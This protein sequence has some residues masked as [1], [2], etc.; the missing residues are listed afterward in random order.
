MSR[1]FTKQITEADLFRPIVSDA[2]LKSYA[3]TPLHQHVQH[4][5][6]YSNN[7]FNLGKGRLV[8]DV[9]F[10]RSV[11]R[12]FSHPELSDIPGL[13]L[14]LNSYMYD[15]KYY[16]PEWSGWQL[17]T[18]VNGMFQQNRVTSG[19]EF[20]IPSYRQFDLGPFAM[21]KKNFDKLDFSAGIR[22]D[23]RSFNNDALYTGT[24]PVTGF[25]Q[26]VTGA[27]TAGAA[28]PFSKYHHVF[29]GVSGSL[30]LTYAFSPEW[31]AKA[32]ISRGYRSP[33][34][35]EISANGVHPG[36]GIYQ[37]GN[38]DFKPEFS[39]QEDIGVTYSSRYV[40]LEL[41]AFYNSL[42]HY[43]YNEKLLTAAGT[44]SIK[45]GNTAYAFQQGKA[46][47]YGGEAS[48][49]VHPVKQLHFENSISFVYGNRRASGGKA[50]TDSNKYLPLIPPVHGLSELRL[51][52]AGKKYEDA[53]IKVQAAWFATQNRVYL[54]DNT[55]TPTPG[56]ALIN[57]GVGTGLKN[58]NDRKWV[59]IY[60]MVNNIF[61]VAYQDHLSRLKYFEEYPTDPRGHHGIY[62]VGRNFSLK[63]DFPF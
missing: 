10:Q 40:R 38:P 14:Q 25:D 39:V 7:N 29:S 35:S 16:F 1:R 19:T 22:Y 59:N 61:D 21:I 31:S 44:D 52:F 28:M 57:A 6:A 32:N 62:G 43:I 55:E 53:F 27:D 47:L 15:V 33:N 56:Y 3:I 30:G 37:I 18:G 51:E 45:D 12:E 48:L 26:A 8:V 42:D 5:R 36:T 54:E 4:Y 41:S 20:I 9:G 63:L 24:N 11:R 46:D 34:I 60:F 50:S 23:S 13:Y 49:D 17:S 2:E 58:R